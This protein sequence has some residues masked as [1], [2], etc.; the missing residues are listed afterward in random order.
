MGTGNW[1][2]KRRWSG[3]R[4]FGGRAPLV[5]LCGLALSWPQSGAGQDPAARAAEALTALGTPSNDQASVR[6]AVWPAIPA[7]DGDSQSFLNSTVF[8]IAATE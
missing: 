3:P 8:L 5:L 1:S 4:P 2:E 6:D 7:R